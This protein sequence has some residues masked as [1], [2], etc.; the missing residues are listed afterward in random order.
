MELSNLNNPVKNKPNHKNK[1]SY[2]SLISGDKKKLTTLSTNLKK[3]MEKSGLSEAELSRRTGIKQPI[4]HRLLSGENNN[5]KLQTI[6]PIADYFLVT[7]SQLIGEDKIMTVWEGLTSAKHQGWNKVKIINLDKVK[8]PSCFEFVITEAKI[9]K[10]SFAMYITDQSME[11]LFPNGCVI[12]A[13]PEMR[14]SNKSYVIIDHSTDGILLRQMIINDNRKF[15]SPIN[16]NFGTIRD[17]TSKDKLLGV[18][19]RTI[20]DHGP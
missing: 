14:P 19:V 9:S 16:F 2:Q 12:I 18:V 20:Y 5:P 4:I 11:P 17:F 8:K 1:S 3:L 6:K 7:I 15:I 10:N 13:E